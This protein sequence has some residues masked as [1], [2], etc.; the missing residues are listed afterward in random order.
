MKVFKVVSNNS[1][2]P[3]CERLEID[4]NF[5]ML[6]DIFLDAL[7]AFYPSIETISETITLQHLD[8]RKVS[9]YHKFP[10]IKGY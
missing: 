8:A 10:K 4:N 6:R 1:I 3:Y 9:V 2:L 5:S 7:E